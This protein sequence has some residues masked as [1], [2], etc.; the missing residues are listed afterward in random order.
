M[1]DL[2]LGTASPPGTTGGPGA[3]PD[4]ILVAFAEPAPQNRLTVLVRIILAIPHLVVLYALSIAAEVVLII[5]WFAALFLGRLPEGLGDFLCGY[6]RWV[7]R[8]QAYLLLLTDQYP[9]FALSE[10]DYPVQ[11]LLRPGRLNRLAVFFRIILAIP[12]SLLAALVTLGM[13]TIVLFV[14]WLIV[15]IMGRMP[16]SLYEAFAAGLRYYLRH[17]GYLFLLTGTYPWGLF[18][19]QPEAGTGW[20][21]MV[22]SAGPG[23]TGYQPPAGYVQPGDE[24]PAGYGQ[25]APGYGQPGDESAAGYSAPAPAYPG[26]GYGLAGASYAGPAAYGQPAGPTRWLGG[27]Q[28]WRLVLSSGAKGLVGMFLAIGALVFV[29]Y[30]V[31]IGVAI[32]SST[33]V[34]KAAAEL[35]VKTAYDSLGSTV[36]SFDS[37]VSACGGKLSC[38]NRVDAQMSRAFATFGSQLHGVAMPTPASSAASAT[39][40]SDANQIATDFQQLSTASSASQYQQTVTS[41]GL[42]G[43]L[44]QFDADYQNLNQALGVT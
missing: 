22:P 25:P 28:P 3:T 11:I 1:T 29:L 14:T 13:E 36:T 21:A 30:A 27:E 24:P 41:T 9:P 32:S 33:T 42:E 39:L 7:A 34:S 43:R 12:A 31:L 10:M 15:L 4:E 5:C 19:D 26:P 38:V 2:P 17:T 18:G 44:S 37:K 23:E 8:V 16:T 35:S 6:L 40:Q 20:P